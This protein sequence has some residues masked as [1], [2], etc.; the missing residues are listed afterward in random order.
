MALT[1]L[2]HSSLDSELSKQGPASFP[3]SL[4][5]PGIEVEQ[6]RKT[7]RFPRFLE[8][9]LRALPCMELWKFAGF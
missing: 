6:G 3:G 1:G 9:R 2:S 4:L 5:F 8:L 7:L